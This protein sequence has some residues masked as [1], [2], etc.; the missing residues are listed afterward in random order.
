V[1]ET[2]PGMEHGAVARAYLTSDIPGVGGRIRE[3]PE[4]F[5]VDEIPAYEPTG[6]DRGTAGAEH[7]AMLVQ[8]KCVS[9]MEMVEVIARHFGVRRSDVGYAGLKDKHAITRQVVTVHVPGKKIEDFPM[10]EH[11]SIGVLWADYHANKLR[12]GHLKGNRFSIRIRGVHFSKVREAKAVLDRLERVGVPNRVGEQR[13]GLLGNNHEVGAA[14]IK[15][16]FER[17][18]SLLLGPDA[19]HPGVN[20]Q[21]RALYAAGDLAGAVHAFP[22]GAR[23]EVAVLRQLLRGMSPRQ[24]VLGV[25]RSMLSFYVSAL[26]SAVFNALLDA[27]LKSGTL[28]SL[29]PGD[30]AFKHDSGAVFAVDESVAID[31]ETTRRLEA[32]EISAS[33]PMWGAGMTRANGAV[34]ERE[35]AALSGAGVTED[36]LSAFSQRGP[37][38]MEGKRRP[39]RVPL[40][41]TDCE[42]GV[43]EHG[44]YVRVVF[45]LPRGAFATAV[46][47]EIMKNEIAEDGTPEGE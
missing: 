44:S 21:A 32:V 16:E 23:A 40:T 34:G 6:K 10:L 29:E 13:F 14:L 17:F 41:N 11:E 35:V 42:G 39:F 8:K 4:D 5:L 20:A 33:G 26:Q 46:L 1:S 43:D 2:P 24:A 25:D 9:T 3:R 36:D 27:R 28:A 18:I 31:P 7:I 12:P 19:A 38:L 22:K 37:A 15:G 30:L 45:D 47:P